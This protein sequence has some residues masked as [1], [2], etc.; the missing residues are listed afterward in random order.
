MSGERKGPA[1]QRTVA[2]SLR[3]NL[4]DAAGGPAAAEVAA[5]V[6][7]A[8][9]AD[10]ADQENLEYLYVDGLEE[11]ADY[12]PPAF[13]APFLAHEVVDAKEREAYSL[14]ALSAMMAK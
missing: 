6:A 1:R 5:E 3:W 13:L 2:K 11:G 4:E 9:A 14:K 7:A 12:E 8:E 10:A